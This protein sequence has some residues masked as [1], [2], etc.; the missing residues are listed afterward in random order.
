M[1]TIHIRQSGRDY[2]IDGLY[3]GD[4]EEGVRLYLWVQGMFPDE[5][6]KALAGVTQ[7]GGYLIQHEE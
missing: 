4:D 3:W 7:A 2:F 1:R 6:A 5:I